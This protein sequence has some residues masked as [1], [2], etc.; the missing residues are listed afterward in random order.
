MTPWFHGTH[1]VRLPTP[2]G[3]SPAG[4]RSGEPSLGTRPSPSQGMRGPNIG[5][6]H[7]PRPGHGQ[8]TTTP[9]PW[10]LGS[11]RCGHPYGVLWSPAM[12]GWVTPILFSRA[13]T[14]MEGSPKTPLF[15]HFWAINGPHS[16][17]H[18]GP[19][20]DTPWNTPKRVVDPLSPV[21]GH[22]MCVMECGTLSG[23]P[24]IP[25]PEGPSSWGVFL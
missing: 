18:P 24:Q 22:V 9:N 14:S 5:I 6:T 11:G 8:T 10:I 20:L 16:G 21:T 23:T 15:G 2:C 25:P 13:R 17:P 7:C 4:L 12:R 1:E 3:V 19:V